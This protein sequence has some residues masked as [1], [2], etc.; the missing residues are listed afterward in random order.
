MIAGSKTDG[1]TFIDPDTMTPERSV[2][3]SPFKL[4]NGFEIRSEK[5]IIK[6]DI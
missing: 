4:D 2:G 1:T 6:L 3:Q 5:E